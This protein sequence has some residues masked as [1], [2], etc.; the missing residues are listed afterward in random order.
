MDDYQGRG[1]DLWA[2]MVTC[3]EAQVNETW[4]TG[5]KE[6]YREWGSNARPLCSSSERIRNYYENN[7]RMYLRKDAEKEGRKSKHK[8]T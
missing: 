5:R 1:H 7:L 6:T 2:P 3:L 4:S 8:A